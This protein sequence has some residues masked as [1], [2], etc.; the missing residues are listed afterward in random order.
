MP[1][2]L[3][4]IPTDAYDFSVRTRIEADNE[5]FAMISQSWSAAL[6]KGFEDL[7]NVLD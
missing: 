5:Q 2:D 3:V 7:P 1:L 6:R 4:V